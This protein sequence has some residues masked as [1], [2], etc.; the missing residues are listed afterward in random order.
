[1][2]H[3]PNNLFKLPEKREPKAV[4]D[5]YRREFGHVICKHKVYLPNEYCRACD[6]HEAKVLKKVLFGA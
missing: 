6:E 1:M 5:I 4:E 2:Q 3:S